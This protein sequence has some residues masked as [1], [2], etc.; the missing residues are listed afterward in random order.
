MMDDLHDFILVK[1]LISESPV[2]MEDGVLVP[3]LEKLL[4][5]RDADKE[6][7]ALGDNTIQTEFQRAFELYPVNISRLLR[8]AGRK[9]KKEE[10]RN[11]V[12]RIDKQRV[13]VVR[14]I[15]EFFRQEPVQR[16]WLF[17]SFSRMEER[18]DSDIDILIDLDRSVSM[19]LLQYAGMINRLEGRLGRKVDLVAS[20]SVKPFARDSINSDKVLIYERA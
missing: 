18:Q 8:Y 12:E 14:T 17:G 11:R 4:V 1:P 3:E 6:Y 13:S 16:A 9:G 20:G 5:D 10:I 7:A 2:Y 19:G 15:Q